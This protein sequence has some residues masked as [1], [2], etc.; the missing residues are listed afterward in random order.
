MSGTSVI[1]EAR[2]RLFAHLLDSILTLDTDGVPSLADRGNR[3]SVAIAQHLC[4]QLGELRVAIKQPGQGQGKVFEKAVEAFV[5][6]VFGELRHLRPGRW[7]GTEE[8]GFLL[9]DFEQ[10]EHLQQLSELAEKHPELASILGNDYVI[11]PDLILARLPES[12]AAI[13]AHKVLVGDGLA[14]ESALR[15]TN[16][17][18]PILHASISCKWTLRSDRAQNARSEA[19]NL[20]RNR[21]GRAPHIVIVTAEPTPSRLA[22]LALGTGDLDC[23]YHIALYELRNSLL[24]LAYEDA[25]DTFDRMVEGKRLKDISDLPL[26]LAV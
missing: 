13:N 12:D 24:E 20:I 21:R 22:S 8:K 19:L 10:Y 7:L 17:V 15:E 16:N 2:Q 26:D 23:V 9:S 18:R 14:S 4:R 5:S 11:K 3:A 1:A 25:L 6:S